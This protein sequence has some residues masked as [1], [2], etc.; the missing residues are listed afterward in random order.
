MKKLLPRSRTYGGSW[1]NDETSEEQLPTQVPHW[2]RVAANSRTL[3][4]FVARVSGFAVAH[5]GFCAAQNPRL[6]RVV[7]R[8]AAK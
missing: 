7:T 2:L 5:P 8:C 3:W 6:A 4:H 1:P